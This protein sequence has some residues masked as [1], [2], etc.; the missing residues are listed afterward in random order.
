MVHTKK[1][2]EKLVIN[3]FI[4]PTLG[5]AL[6]EQKNQ[7]E[8]VPSFFEPTGNARGIKQS[9]EVNHSKYWDVYFWI[10]VHVPLGAAQEECIV[11]ICSDP[12]ISHEEHVLLLLKKNL[13]IFN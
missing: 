9:T 1:V 11:E 13:F 2:L 12:N 3:C 7:E 6:G 8:I 5:F 4:V 10:C